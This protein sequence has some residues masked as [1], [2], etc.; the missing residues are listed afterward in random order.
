[1]SDI[2]QGVFISFNP[3]FDSAM[4][5]DELIRQIPDIILE[6]GK[7]YVENG[8]ILDLEKSKYGYKAIVEGNYGDYDVE[9]EMDAKGNVEDYFCNCPFDGDLCKHIAAVALEIE[10]GNAIVINDESSVKNDWK[11]LIKKTGLDELQR[12]L[13]DYGARNRDFQ[14]QVVMTFSEPESVQNVDNIPYYRTQIGAIF[15]MY[16]DGYNYNY[17]SA[18]N[19]TFEVNLFTHKAED[20][21]EKGNLNEAFSIAAAIAIESAEAIQYMDDS[22][23]YLGGLVNEA[24]EIIDKAFNK[25]KDKDIK[26][27]IYQWLLLQMK[28]EN[29][30]NYGLE[31]SL[32]SIFFYVVEK[33]AKYEDAYDFIESKLASSENKEEWSSQYSQTKFLKYKIS[34]LESQNK[35]EEVEIL[36]SNN[37]YLSDLRRIRVT[38]LI[39]EQNYKDA[40]K[41]ILDGIRIALEKS[42]GGTV[43][44]WKELLLNIYKST[45]PKKYSQLL[46]ELFLENTGEFEYYKLYKSTVPVDVWDEEC[47]K[48][49][50]KLKKGN[51]GR[52]WIHY[53]YSLAKIYIEEQMI[54]E[55]FEWTI[56]SN[57]I[58]TLISYTPHLKSKYNSELIDYYKAAIEIEAVNTGRNVYQSIVEY[59]KQMA[60][61]KGGELAVIELKNALL[62]KYKNRPAMAEEFSQL[63]F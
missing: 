31:D 59:L 8:N 36:I 56:S 9:I 51:K 44:N 46:L 16:G 55:L 5:L 20:F 34:L 57:N 11:E 26:E 25:T 47:Q 48:I 54:D 6:R 52:Y 27:R 21:L 43:K 15:D 28:N 62:N 58:N 33:M 13:I 14:H 37:M 18:Y 10:D 2:V 42:E 24:F 39:E 49:I 1:M 12:F 45:K 53:D 19:S 41:L 4:K 63:K 7:H 3:K 38:R 23:G 22:D 35:N 30:E 40:E 50:S 32:E 60:K 17:R 29:Y 61:L